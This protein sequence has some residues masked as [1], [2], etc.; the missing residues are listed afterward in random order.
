MRRH[1]YMGFVLTLLVA[2]MACPET[3][4]NADRPLTAGELAR[5]G[6]SSTLDA[7]EQLR[8]NWLRS[9]GGQQPVVHI[10]SRCPHTCLRWVE[11][12]LV[13]EVRYVGPVAAAVRWGKQYPEGVLV[14]TLRQRS[15]EER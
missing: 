7:V 1:P 15:G 4:A 8:P 2:V 6:I 11:S 3:S 9:R 14:V 5:P 10:E 13:E 12:D